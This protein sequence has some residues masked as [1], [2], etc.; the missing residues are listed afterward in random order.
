[1]ASADDYAAWIV[2][3][4]DKRGTPEFATVAAA[5]QQAKSESAPAAGN[6][7]EQTAKADTGGQNLLASVGGAMY[8][9][10]LGA[11]QLLGL[12]SPDEI[13]QYKNSMAGLWSTPMGKAGTVLGGIAATAPAAV[14][15][16]ASVPAAAAVGAGLGA[17]QPTGEGESRLQNAATGGVGGAAGQGAATLLGKGAS[18][19]GGW[20]SQKAAE[21]A[22]KN[23][24]LGATIKE[25]QNAGYV[26]PPTQVN[27]GSVVNNIL[28]GFS[29]KIK[30]GQSAA[31]KNESVTASL[32]KQAIGA[33]QDAPLNNATINAI[34]SEAGKA[35]TAVRQS[36]PVVADDQYGSDF[37]KIIG[38]YQTLA[39]QFPS[40][41]NSS[42]DALVKDLSLDPAKPIDPSTVVDLVRRLRK[43]GF[44]NL[45]SEHPETAQ[46]G[47]IQ[48]GAQNAL[49]DLLDRN[50]QAS[51]N[52]ELLNNF[53]QAR[54]LF[55][56]TY[57]VEKALE[58][59]TG[60]IVAS[61]IGREF[62]K[63]KP[64]TGELAT[65]GK[66][67]EAFPKAVQN[68]NTSMPALSPLDYLGG[69]LGYTIHPAY[70]AAALARPLVRSAI[71]SKPYQ[72][73][74]AQPQSGN[75]GLLARGLPALDNDALK[76]IEKLGL[77]SASLQLPRF[78][79][80]GNPQQ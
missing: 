27:P 40:Q 36:S 32:A 51:G 24:T 58:D 43:D 57:T 19:L 11:K 42:I 50:L 62:S 65:I 53:R 61:K 38:E 23:A 3:N 74:M 80:W 16:G 71:L 45:R 17:L 25:A 6:A 34:R 48:I 5:Y 28:E 18:A 20:L 13:Q 22:T 70:A 55:A 1:M 73:L 29:G 76:M 72:S 75:G 41:R 52:P 66:V 39:E 31:A 2:K 56:K 35:Y 64:L 30:T 78:V 33:P 44:A 4:A 26:L 21:A 7:Y 49:E 54:A 60:K 79:P 68:V 9:P 67:A 77:T 12:S 47:Q 15:A 8:G 69:G 37:G 14:A 63:G 59:S 10:Y 46:L